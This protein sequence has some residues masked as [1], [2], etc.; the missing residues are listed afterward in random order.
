[1]FVQDD[2]KVSSRLTL[3]LGVRWE[4]W[5]QPAERY[6]QQA[7]FLPQFSK[8]D[9]AL[10]QTPVGIPASAIM[11]IPAG[12]DLRTLLITNT[13]N[14]APRIGLAYQVAKNTVIRGGFGTFYADEPFIGGTGRLPA[15][16]PFYRDVTLS[17]D[18]IH[19]VLQLSTGF[20]ANALTNNFNFSSAS[21]IG[22]AQDFQNGYVYHWSFGV[23]Q[24]IGRFTAEANYVGTKGTDLPT[25]FNINAA[26]PGAGS[27]AS[28]RPYQGFGDI[29]NTQPLDSTSYHALE[30]RLQRQW[31]S[32]L[33]LLFSYTYSKSIDIGGEQLISDAAIRNVRNVDLEKALST[34]DLRHFFTG[35]Y[36]YALPFGHGRRFDLRNGVVNGVLG[37][38]QFNGIT[39][40]RSGL[41]FTPALGVSSANTGDPRPNRIGNGNRPSDQRTL[42]N[43]FDKTAFTV[44]AAFTFGNAGRD[45]LFGP[46][47]VNFDLSLFK[48]FAIPKIGEA[49]KLQL[50]FESFNT[51]NHPQFSNPSNRVDLPQGGT[52]TSLSNNMRDLQAGI[53]LIF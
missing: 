29:T 3:N 42:V 39:T 17:T 50:R 52:I 48:D 28:R 53:K 33:T 41:P 38:W 11:P 21:L 37:N 4:V 1:L 47:A 24:Q 8:M 22:W 40:I 19:P 14:F 5:T 12:V 35:S 23:Q 25:T 51:F 36:S 2:W 20:P 18:Q 44:P 26:Y 45:I 30:L 43:W 31:S 16:P 15:N 13:K 49:G 7:N 32:G 9:F 34:A 10:N 46:G 27:V 6:N